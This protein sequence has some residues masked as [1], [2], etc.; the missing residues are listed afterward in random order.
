LER[1]QLQTHLAE[2]ASLTLGLADRFLP[3]GFLFKNNN[4]NHDRS[5]SWRSGRCHLWP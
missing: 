2:Q 5:G 3:G 1:Y 4:L